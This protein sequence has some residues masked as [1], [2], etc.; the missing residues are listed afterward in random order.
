M[1]D[2]NAASLPVPDIAPDATDHRHP[3]SLVTASAASAEIRKATTDLVN[4]PP[5]R[6][7]LITVTMGAGK[8]KESRDLAAASSL[9]WIFL[10]PTHALAT[11][12]QAVLETLGAASHHHR[13]VTGFRL[14]EHAGCVRH[15][16]AVSLV[17]AGISPLK[18]L[19]PSCPHKLQH[20][21]ADGVC[22]AFEAAVTLTN[23]K[24]RLMQQTRM[25]NILES[26][27][28]LL[29]EGAAPPEIL[30][31][32]EPP[33]L[34]QVTTLIP[35]HAEVM[36]S[37][38]DTLQPAV[39]RGVESA[40]QE[41]AAHL[42][43]GL[44]S[45]FT[46]ADLLS[47][48][49]I[50]RMKGTTNLS[51]AARIERA[52]AALPS[53]P[54]IAKLGNARQ[55]VEALREAAWLP[56]RKSIYSDTDGTIRLVTRA[57]WV[58]QL[59]RW[60]QRGG[61]ALILD[62]T[63]NRADYRALLLGKENWDKLAY[64]E[65]HVEDAPGVKRVYYRW[66]SGARSR[67]LVGAA[68]KWTE[69]QGVLRHLCGVVKEHGGPVGIISDKPT[70]TA[71]KQILNAV[72]GE[73]VEHTLPEE[74]L[75][76]IRTGVEFKI[77]WYGAHRGLDDWANCRVLATVGDPF[78]NVGDVR[79]EAQF[80][81]R[82]ERAHA[83]MK[84]MAE[85][86][87]ASGRARPIHRTDQVVMVHYG[88]SKPSL[89]LAPQW[90]SA[91]QVNVRTGRPRQKL[92]GGTTDEELVRLKKAGMSVRE[93]ARKIGAAP[94]TVHRRMGKARDAGTPGAE[95]TPVVV[96][97]VDQPSTNCSLT[98]R[99]KHASTNASVQPRLQLQCDAAAL[100]A[101]LQHVGK[102]SPLEPKGRGG[103]LV[104]IVDGRAH[105]YSSGTNWIARAE[106]A[107]R[108]DQDG[109]FILPSE[110][111][112]SLIAV[113]G[114]VTI[115]SR[116][117]ENEFRVAY[118]SEAGS[119]DLLSFDPRSFPL[120][121]RDPESAAELKV[122]DA[123]VLSNALGAMVPFIATKADAAE[124]HFSSVRVFSEPPKVDG[125][126]FAANGREAVWF[127]CESLRGLDMTIGRDEVG[128]LRRLT[129]K[130]RT[131]SISSHDDW[132][133]AKNDCTQVVGWKRCAT[134]RQYMWPATNDDTIAFTV[135]RSQVVARLEALF[136]IAK[137]EDLS[138]S[139]RHGGLRIG[140]DSDGDPIATIAVK[141]DDIGVIAKVS[142]QALLRLFVDGRLDRIEVRIRV[143]PGGLLLRTREGF[144]IG[145]ARCLAARFAPALYARDPVKATSDALP[146][147][148]SQESVR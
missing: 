138:F 59:A 88:K 102:S 127:Y 44:D 54:R 42:A 116:E 3:P 50:D 98:V 63:A 67:H 28:G 11:Q 83:Y 64:H 120:G 43:C 115:S 97:P 96:T 91:E 77:G 22:P 51:L 90:A 6:A 46:L 103:H 56:G 5:G 112:Q 118:A 2:A 139:Y 146:A 66:G 40:V 16:E 80:L 126:M 135:S 92:N 7:S 18:R 41:F 129:A 75:E 123:T 142:A 53:D 89:W 37:W 10:L 13:G 27:L 14:G 108:C 79:A 106:L 107:V 82:D 136:P 65:I 29:A 70:A 145:G 19:C 71:L 20:P 23:A 60:I 109:R 74:L 39:R 62:A 68:P 122:I 125:V 131:I 30:V 4:G 72:A 99:E 95:P 45:T 25:A 26:R 58:R 147:H 130:S 137:D 86:V 100:R 128:R 8:S 32:D 15:G 87:Q 93:I 49:A 111:A 119:V 85:I 73:P 134:Y 1:V 47:P 35:R 117:A 69:F 12:H 24:V 76:L 114:E 31:I 140:L 48:A 105:V 104:S 57:P 148:A 36:T 110:L 33:P 61:R 52:A 9:P 34:L 101:A 143:T 55:I 113:S 144:A 17:R 132:F 124:E 133:F 121:A 81:Q 94:T 84:C 21:I 78:P 38:L 141:S